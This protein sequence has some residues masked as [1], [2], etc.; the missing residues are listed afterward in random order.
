[1]WWP[2]V[3]FRPIFEFQIWKTKAIVYWFIFIFHTSDD[4]PGSFRVYFLKTGLNAVIF[5]YC[6]KVEVLLI[7]QLRIGEQPVRQ[8]ADRMKCYPP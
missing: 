6:Y 3:K 8:C 2:H 1:M 7:H 5:R 4:T